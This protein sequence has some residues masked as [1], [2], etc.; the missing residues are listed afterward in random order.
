MTMTGESVTDS[1]VVPGFDEIWRRARDGDRDARTALVER[2]RNRLRRFVERRMGAGVRRQV[3]PEDVV[4]STMLTFFDRLAGF[5]DD[6]DEAQARAY[7]FQIAKWRIADIAE[8]AGRER[9]DSVFPESAV[10]A[11]VSSAG[12]VTRHDDVRWTRDQIDGLPKDYAEVMRRFYVDGIRVALI[13]EELGV[14]R[15][16]VKQRLHRGRNMIR[17]DRAAR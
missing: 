17:A 3:E 6:L 11:H 9:G 12:P 2:Y 14:A 7:L 13:A 16:V 10:A 1:D 5:P 8:R 15:D 4:Q